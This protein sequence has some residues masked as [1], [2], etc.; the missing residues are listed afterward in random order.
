[1]TVENGEE[2]SNDVPGTDE[3]DIPGVDEKEAAD[4]EDDNVGDISVEINVEEL[5]ADIEASGTDEAERD[6][7]IRE[8]LDK[9]REQQ[10]D[11]LDSTYNFNLDEDL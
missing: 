4:A 10:D 8:K 11:T 6:A 9:I 1:M 2:E 7:G 5:V 3:K